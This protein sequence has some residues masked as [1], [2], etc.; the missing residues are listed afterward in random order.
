[1]NHRDLNV[2]SQ[3][4]Q[5]SVHCPTTTTSQFPDIYRI[6]DELYS[7]LV[8]FAHPEEDL[9]ERLIRRAWIVVVETP[10]Y[11][12]AGAAVRHET[13][14]QNNACSSEKILLAATHRLEWKELNH[15]DPD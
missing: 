13:E 11:L 12:G 6:K 8:T 14:C 15:F 3:F 9:T 2:T 7:P 5:G 4:E 1:M 10:P